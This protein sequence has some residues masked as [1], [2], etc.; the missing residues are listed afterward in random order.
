MKPFDCF[1]LGYCVSHSNC[2]WRINL[3]HHVGEEGIEMLTQ[4]AVE[5][6]TH[7]TGGISEMNLSMNNI[8]SEGVKQ[9]LD[10]PTHLIDGLESLY[11]DRNNLNSGA[12]TA[13]AHFIPRIPH[14]KRLSL[15]DNP[16]IGQGGAV[17]LIS[18]LTHCK[19]FRLL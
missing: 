19:N 12:C 16:A 1:V 9:L 8:R 13:L 2:A 7:C 6:E 4:G 15:S 3:A 14:L 10:F 17:L 11:L 5:E 18:S